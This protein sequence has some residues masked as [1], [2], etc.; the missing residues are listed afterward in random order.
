[1]PITTHRT[2]RRTAGI[3]AAALLALPAAAQAADYRGQLSESISSGAP[4]V[5]PSLTLRAVIDNGTGRRAGR[6]RLPPLHD[7]CASSCP[8][9]LDVADRGAGGN[10]TRHDDQRYL[11]PRSEPLRVLGQGRDATGQ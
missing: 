8:E 1:M 5:S 4:G 9:R 7:R 11:W 6:D 3:C 10:A 2:L